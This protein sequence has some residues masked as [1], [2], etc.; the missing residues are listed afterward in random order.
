VKNASFSVVAGPNAKTWLHMEGF[1]GSIPAAGGKAES[2]LKI[3][4]IEVAGK[5]VLT[6][7]RP[8][9][10]WQAPFL[11]VKPM[12]GKLAD[13]IGMNYQLAARIGFLAG[14]PLQIEARIPEQA[15]AEFRAS[16]AL[17]AAFGKLTAN[18]RFRGLLLAPQT[19]Q[20]DL[21][22]QVREVSAEFGKHRASFDRG[23][24]IVVLRGGILSCVDARLVGDELSFLGNATVLADGRLAGALRM[25]A[26]P[27]HVNGMVKRTFKYLT[28]PIS[29]TPLSTD[30]RTAF[31]IQAF[32][33]FQQIYMRFGREGPVMRVKR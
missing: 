5:P 28:D 33:T 26:P 20:G 15:L 8:I 14:L 10:E 30:Q 31:D 13:G 11:A 7:F 19:W 25:V 9:L 27:G 6:H 12:E 17:G 32:G 21:V 3:R 1:N 29:L 24:G 22:G 2:A 4:S 23:S 16:E 18:S